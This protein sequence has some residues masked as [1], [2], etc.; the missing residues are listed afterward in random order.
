MSSWQNHDVFQS[1]ANSTPLSVLLFL[2]FLLFLK[3]FLKIK[4]N[5]GYYFPWFTIYK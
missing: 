3:G 5:Q 1:S 2:P 4:I